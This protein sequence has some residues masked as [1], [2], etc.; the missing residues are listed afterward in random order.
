MCLI[1]AY[2]HLPVLD[3]NIFGKEEELNKAVMINCIRNRLEL[4]KSREFYVKMIT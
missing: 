2:F 4:L 3:F 1:S